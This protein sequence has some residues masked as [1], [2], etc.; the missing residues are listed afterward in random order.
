MLLQISAYF[1][2]FSPLYPNTFVH[3]NMCINSYCSDTCQDIQTLTDQNYLLYVVPQVL[4]LTWRTVDA[5]RS[6]LGLFSL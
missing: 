5:V 3:T 1:F 4:L 6:Y 2:S